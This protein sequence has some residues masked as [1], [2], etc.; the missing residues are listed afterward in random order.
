MAVV[1]ADEEESLRGAF[2]AL[3]AL[4]A[5]PAADFIARRLRERRLRGLPRGPRKAT[6]RNAANLTSREL[7]VL[8]MLGQGLRNAEVA[9]RLFLSPRTVDHHVASIMR[10]LGVRSRGEAVASWRPRW[11]SPTPVIRPRALR[12]SAVT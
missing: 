11:A 7:E 9:D 3:Q 5:R 10:K 12:H 8:G 6:K 4:G 2:E 1:E